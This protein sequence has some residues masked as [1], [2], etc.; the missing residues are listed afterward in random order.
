MYIRVR[1]TWA[2]PWTSCLSILIA[3]TAGRRHDPIFFFWRIFKAR[4]QQIQRL[5]TIK[6][7]YILKWLLG[8]EALSTTSMWHTFIFLLLHFTMPLPLKKQ[9]I[10]TTPLWVSEIY[11]K[12]RMKARGM[13]LSFLPRQ[14]LPKKDKK[15]KRFI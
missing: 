11:V 4:A 12:S 6:K 3:R 5:F 8:T 1:L 7:S 14:G 2:S 15:Q 13:C 9:G 10:D